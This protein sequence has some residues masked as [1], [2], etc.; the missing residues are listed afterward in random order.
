VVTFAVAPAG[1]WGRLRQDNPGMARWIEWVV[2]RRWWII[3]LTATAQGLLAYQSSWLDVDRFADFGRSLLVGDWGM[4]Y[5]DDWNQSGPVQLIVSYVITTASRTGVGSAITHAVIA[6]AVVL[7]VRSGCRAVRAAAGLPAS[8]S[9]E[10]VVGG[11][12]AFV[13]I[14]Y[15]RLWETHP[16]QLAIPVL[17]V[18]A[19][20][21]ARA[22][23]PVSAGVLLGFAV[24]WEP[25]AVLGFP[26]VLMLGGLAAA[27]R[28]SVLASL[29]GAAWYLPFVLSGHF[30]LFDH[31]WRISPNSVLMQTFGMSGEQSWMIR[32]VQAVGCLAV[33]SGIVLRLRPRASAVWLAP[34]GAMLT[35]LVFDAYVLDYHWFSVSVLPLVGLCLFAGHAREWLQGCCVLAL[36][37]LPYVDFQLSWRLL[38]SLLLVAVAVVVSGRPRRP[39]R[40]TPAGSR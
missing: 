23:R 16:A 26:V 28:A 13:L 15:G 32:L 21:V 18:A 6:L 35:R 30:A 1:V 36:A 29:V 3:A 12:T 8:A 39:V 17:W 7:C 10:C 24:G 5:R 33:C 9:I 19:G 27:V 37:Y 22:G 20:L 31:R 25:W 14:P 4:V 34:L 2:L 40:R 11:L 38:V